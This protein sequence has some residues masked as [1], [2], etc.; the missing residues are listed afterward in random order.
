M[1]KN[2]KRLENKT[3]SGWSGSTG[4]NAPMSEQLLKL[5]VEMEKTACLLRM[6]SA[7]LAPLNKGLY[8][9]AELLEDAGLS[10]VTGLDD[11]DY[12]IE[13][14]RI[15]LEAPD[16]GDLWDGLRE[17]LP[18]ELCARMEDADISS[19][20]VWEILERDGWFL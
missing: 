1:Q 17:L 8:L 20:E 15:L 2:E 7:G 11:L 16:E 6:V 13:E 12:T 10:P 19:H 5:A 4:E 3:G 14:G 18:E 9:P